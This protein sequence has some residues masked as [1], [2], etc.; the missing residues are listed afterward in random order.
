[1]ESETS[2]E[3]RKA[4]AQ[5]YYESAKDL[6][7][8]NDLSSAHKLLISSTRLYDLGA[9]SNLLDKVEA[10]LRQNSSSHINAQSNNIKS[11]SFSASSEKP[12][13]EIR[14]RNVEQQQRQRD[15]QPS[16]HN[17][18]SHFSGSHSS[19][20]AT[21]SSATS[22]SSSNSSASRAPNA[23]GAAAPNAEEKEFT[24]EQQLE[25]RK[26]VQLGKKKM[27]Y[28]ILSVT[29]NANEG[30]IKAAYK[31][32]A[33]R[34][35]PDK[36][37]APEAE[38]AFKFCSA[39]YQ[40][41]SDPAKKRHFDMTGDDDTQ[42]TGAAGGGGAHP[43]GGAFRQFHFG[44]D[45]T[46]DDIFNA[47]FTNLNM[48]RR[49][50]FRF[51]QSHQQYQQEGENNQRQSRRP[52]SWIQ[53]LYQLM[54]LLFMLLMMLLQGWGSSSFSNSPAFSLDRSND[55][56]F[57]RTTAAFDVPYYVRSDFMH[58]AQDARALFKIE[59]EVEEQYMHNLEAECQKETIMKTKAEQHAKAIASSKNDELEKVHLMKRPACEKLK[60][61]VTKKT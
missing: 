41:L 28:E 52:H 14:R 20:S 37:K 24:V 26:M 61:L 34:F 60:K 21:A 39:A 15:A 1:M 42:S 27:Y 47:F 23:G 44:D 22:F 25:A 13:Q 33:L 54:P 7:E 12:D 46:G 32:L 55:Y 49:G 38:E 36:N 45:A 29:K 57:H 11:S 6:F 8:Q 51:H 3:A 16:S 9:A 31:K 5:R 50:A 35:H 2:D 30:T 4:Q 40:V 18:A 58:R 19:S 10:R 43:F 56:Q 17:S 53:S 59:T 48:P